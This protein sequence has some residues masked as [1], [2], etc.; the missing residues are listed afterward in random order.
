MRSSIFLIFWKTGC[1]FLKETCGNGWGPLYFCNAEYEESGGRLNGCSS[2]DLRSRGYCDLA[3]YSQPIAQDYY[4]YF[5]D[6]KKG[7]RESYMGKYSSE[8]A[9]RNGSTVVDISITTFYFKSSSLS[10]PRSPLSKTPKQVFFF[11]VINIWSLL[12]HYNNYYQILL[13]FI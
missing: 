10:S 12:T 5:P 9:S 8:G 6:T 2:F 3:T 4:R 7:G 13:F 1:N 11:N